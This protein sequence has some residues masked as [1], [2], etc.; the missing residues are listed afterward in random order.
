MKTMILL[1]LDLPPP[2][3]AGL[4]AGTLTGL[5]ILLFTLLRK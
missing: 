2:T 5:F 1:A 4:S 3:L